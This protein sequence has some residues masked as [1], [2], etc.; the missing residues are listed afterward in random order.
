MLTTKI[1]FH[2]PSVKILLNAGKHVGITLPSG[3][4]KDS[5]NKHVLSD[6]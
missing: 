2:A 5:Q 3:N 6:F 1:N 4:L